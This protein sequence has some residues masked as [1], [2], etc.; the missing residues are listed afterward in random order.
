MNDRYEGMKKNISNP[1]RSKICLSPHPQTKSNPRIG[2]MVAK[3][4]T[5]ATASAVGADKLE[6]VT[7]VSAMNF[8]E[9]LSDEE[10]FEVGFLL[11]FS[12][13]GAVFRVLVSYF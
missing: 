4:E 9:G 13:G 5:I 11:S 3:F 7:G 10:V 2:K 1:K 8:A 6:A 12:V